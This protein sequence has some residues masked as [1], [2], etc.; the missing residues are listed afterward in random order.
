VEYTNVK[1]LFLVGES[2]LFPETLVCNTVNAGKPCEFSD[3]GR[4]PGLVVLHESQPGYSLDKGKS[5]D[6]CPACAYQNLSHVRHWQ[7]HGG[8][9]FPDDLLDLRLFKCRMGYWLVV[10]GLTENEPSQ[11]EQGQTNPSFAEQN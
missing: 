6:L 9:T 1:P 5:G 3:N 11:V 4:M 2:H 7:G 8:E 10:P